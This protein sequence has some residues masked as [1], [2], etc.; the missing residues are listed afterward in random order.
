MDQSAGQVHML[1]KQERRAQCIYRVISHGQEPIR[2]HTLSQVFKNEDWCGFE[3]C[4][5]TIVVSHA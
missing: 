1:V 5:N 3:T 4:A 2:L